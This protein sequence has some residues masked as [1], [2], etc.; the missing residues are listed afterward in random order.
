MFSQRLKKLREENHI[1][2]QELANILH[3]TRATISGYET[4]GQNPDYDKLVV[5]CSFFNVS[6]DYLLGIDIEK[7]NGTTR[8]YTDDELEVLNYYNKLTKDN[9]ILILAQMINHIQQQ[10]AHGEMRKKDIG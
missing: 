8:T 3:V 9:K 7:E 5:I 4:K 10:D 6:A 2:Q 1:T